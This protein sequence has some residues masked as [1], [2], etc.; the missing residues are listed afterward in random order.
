MKSPIQCLKSPCIILLF[1]LV[2][3]VPVFAQVTSFK[4]S[5]Y[6]YRTPLYRSLQLDLFLHEAA[7]N[8]NDKV[9]ADDQKSFN[10]DF[11]G[12]IQQNQTIATDERLHQSAWYAYLQSTG[13]SNNSAAQKRAKA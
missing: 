7:L 2:A 10:Y 12:S 3:C 9:G 1:G 13:A 4:L 8:R 11:D 6:K 5:D